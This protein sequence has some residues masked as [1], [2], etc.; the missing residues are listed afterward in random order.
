MNP[1]LS[2][3]NDTPAREAIQD[4]V[5]RVSDRA[6]AAFVAPEERIA[7]FDN[8]G[9]LWCEKP[10]YIQLD[11]ILRRWVEMAHADPELAEQQ[12]WKAAVEKDYTWLGNAVTKHYGGDDSD[13][14]ALMKGL[15][16]A[17]AGTTVENFAAR[18]AEFLHTQSH[19]TLK[20]LYSNCGYAPMVELLRFLEGNGFTNFIASGGGRDFM[21]PITEEMYGIPPDRVIGSSVSLEF[22]ESGDGGDVLTQPHLDVLDDGPV[23]PARIWS[24]IGRRPILAAGNSNGDIQMLEYAN[25]PPRPALRLLVLHDDAEREFDY[26]G[27]AEKSLELARQYGWTVVSMKQDW[28]TIFSDAQ[29]WQV[30]QPGQ[31]SPP[32]GDVG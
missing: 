30:A 24:R 22:R 31:K 11:F 1:G 18:A 23:K 8:D 28:D 29:S 9:T 14:P 15:T 6:S 12:P 20:R 3:W 27:G 26:V 25:Q 19:P 2:S 10:M 21:R 7:V 4:F 17:F 32:K 16:S 5:A 13:L